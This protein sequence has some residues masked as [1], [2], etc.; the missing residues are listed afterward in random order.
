MRNSLRGQTGEFYRGGA[1]THGGVVDITLQDQTLDSIFQNGHI[2]NQSTEW[3]YPLK[4][5]KSRI[6]EDKNN[7]FIVKLKH[8]GY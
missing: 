3:P 8:R 1:E 4:I 7:I 6:V 2:K 5:A